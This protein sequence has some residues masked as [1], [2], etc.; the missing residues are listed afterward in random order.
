MLSLCLSVCSSVWASVAYFFL[1][2]LGSFRF[3]LMQ[4]AVSLVGAGRV[5]S[6]IHL[7][8]CSLCLVYVRVLSTTS[9]LQRVQNNLALVVCDVGWRKFNTADL[10]HDLHWLPVRSRVTFKVATLCYQ[11]YRNGQPAYLFLSSCIPPR[12]LRSASLV[13]LFEPPARLAIGERRFSYHA[14]RV[15]NS[16]PMTVRSADS[17]ASFKTRLKTHLFDTVNP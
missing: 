12:N 4:F 9:K 3:L 11:T 6:P 13:R 7:F 16:P 10:L 14:P 5:S 8:L 1:M 15:W 2:Q 17:L